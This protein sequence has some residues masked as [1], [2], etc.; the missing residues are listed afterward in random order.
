MRL[1]ASVLRQEA[2]FGVFVHFGG[3]QL[4][5]FRG[6]FGVYLH[7]HCSVGMAH[8][9]LQGFHRDAGFIA[10]GAEGHAEVM[11]ADPDILPG[12]KGL[13]LCEECL[14][15]LRLSVPAYRAA[16]QLLLQKSEIGLIF[17]GK[18]HSFRWSVLLPYLLRTWPCR[19][20][21]AFLP[22]LAGNAVH[23]CCK[24]VGAGEGAFVCALWVSLLCISLSKR[25]NKKRGRFSTDCQDFIDRCMDLGYRDRE[26]TLEISC[27]R[28]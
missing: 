28:R 5:L 2:S 13:S 6:Q 17:P 3:I 20:I 21:S 24:A 15:L 19:G 10:H 8:S 9:E 11:A 16:V 22:V 1:F 25:R 27:H 26:H 12:R 7:N 18:G 14:V 4:L 23:G